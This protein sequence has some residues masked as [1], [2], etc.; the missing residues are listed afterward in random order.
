MLKTECDSYNRLGIL[1]KSKNLDRQFGSHHVFR[2]SAYKLKFD[3]HFPDFRFSFFLV[4]YLNSLDH[5]HVSTFDL[6][7]ICT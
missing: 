6:Q 5:I 2:F 7:I 3:A 1:F 4:F